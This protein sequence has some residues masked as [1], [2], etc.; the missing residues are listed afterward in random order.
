MRLKEQYFFL[1]LVML[2]IV[3]VAILSSCNNK[4]DKTLVLTTY[5]RWWTGIELGMKEYF[6]PE[7][8]IFEFRMETA[9]GCDESQL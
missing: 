4:E 9:A 3:F 1:L 5:G 6:V 7:Y 8:I 2:L